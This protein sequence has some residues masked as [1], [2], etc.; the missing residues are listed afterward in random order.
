MSL[1]DLSSAVI[2]DSPPHW[3]CI[4]LCANST[5]A[6]PAPV[7]LGMC[8]CSVPRRF[9]GTAALALALTLA[10]GTV[11]L[12]AVVVVVAVAVVANGL[13]DLV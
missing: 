5:I 6:R 8:V 10:M 3:L 13:A 11:V 9:R 12:A 2:W 4:M 7:Y 1:T